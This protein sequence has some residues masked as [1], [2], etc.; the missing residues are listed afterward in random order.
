MGKFHISGV[1]MELML[2]QSITKWLKI[3][4]SKREHMND[5]HDTNLG[6]WTDRPDRE[7][8]ASSFNP[9]SGPFHRRKPE[10]VWV[11]ALLI[12]ALM[13]GFGWSLLNLAHALS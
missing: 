1:L 9:I 13:G 4:P 6:W 2:Y 8:R 7:P 3:G 5:R 10:R 12:A 11:K